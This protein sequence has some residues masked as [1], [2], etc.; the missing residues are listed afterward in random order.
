MTE[1]A[2][3]LKTGKDIIHKTNQSTLQHATN[4]FA[5]IKQMS[6]EEFNKIFIVIKIKK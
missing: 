4:Y 3:S 6:V 5:K 1:Y 2:M